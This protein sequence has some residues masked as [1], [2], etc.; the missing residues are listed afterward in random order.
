MS[1]KPKLVIV[2]SPY[3]GDIKNNIMYARKCLRH[4]LGLGE[5]PVASHLL[6]T[7]AGI[8]KDEVPEE[9]EMGI[10]AG[11]QWKEIPE[12]LTVFYIDRGVSEG[13]KIALKD[14]IDKGYKYEMRSIEDV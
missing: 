12:S 14:C 3:A 8:L 9:R 2:E 10:M 5:A 13:M 6:Y 1:T 7:Q 11:L 4:S